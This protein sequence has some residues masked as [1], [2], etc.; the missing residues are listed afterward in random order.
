MKIVPMCTHEK[1][2]VEE[3]KTGLHTENEP[4]LFIL[5]TKIKL[6]CLRAQSGQKYTWRCECLADAWLTQACVVHV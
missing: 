3:K 1:K 6:F 4:Y 2:N 5:L